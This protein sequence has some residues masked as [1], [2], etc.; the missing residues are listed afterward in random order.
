MIIVKYPKYETHPLSNPPKT[1]RTMSYYPHTMR[2]R[3]PR[4]DFTCG[5]C[6]NK[7]VWISD[8]Q[9]ANRMTQLST[10]GLAAELFSEAM[11]SDGKGFTLTKELGTL[12]SPGNTAELEMN[13]AAV[14]GLADRYPDL[15]ITYPQ[16]VLS[17]EEPDD[18]D[19]FRPSRTDAVITVPDAF[20]EVH[21]GTAFQQIVQEKFQEPLKELTA[22][23]AKRLQRHE[24]RTAR[25]FDKEPAASFRI[26]AETAESEIWTVMLEHCGFYPLQWDGEVCGMALLLKQT[27]SGAFADNSEEITE[28]TAVRDPK[29]KCC[30]LTVQYSMKQD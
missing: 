28:I 10:E 1:Q 7:Y 9:E 8:E 27:L 18:P 6:Y 24:M 29:Q 4:L 22:Q 5:Y 23:I 21:C 14:R 2:N 20:V 26:T 16:T 15:H 12:Q 25:L 11:R 13:A 3:N 17:D 30:T 19:A